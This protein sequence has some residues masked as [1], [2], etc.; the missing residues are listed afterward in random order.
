MPRAIVIT[1]KVFAGIICGAAAI[2]FAGLS[3]GAGAGVGGLEEGGWNWQFLPAIF[4]GWVF[5]FLLTLGLS[6]YVFTRSISWPLQFGLLL[7]AAPIVTFSLST[8]YYFFALMPERILD[9]RNSE[10]L[11]AARSD[12][13]IV[14]R[15]VG[16]ARIESLIPIEKIAI[17]Q[18]LGQKNRFSHDDTIFLLDYFQKDISA[19]AAIMNRQPVTEEDLRRIFSRYDNTEAAF[20][21]I[22]DELIEHPITPIDI[23]KSITNNPRCP[24]YMT[25]KATEALQ[26]RSNQAVQPTR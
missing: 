20:T 1:V 21:R 7:L 26:K 22:Y 19:V 13:A 12:P 11:S 2:W 14:D 3:A 25:R 4:L 8:G 5:G 15:L 10:F 9:G 6:F 17:G 18:S 24:E 16:R 23:L